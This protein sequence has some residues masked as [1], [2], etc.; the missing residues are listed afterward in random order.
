MNRLATSIAAMLLIA[1][2]IAASCVAGMREDIRFHLSMRAGG[3]EVELAFDR[4]GHGHDRLSNTMPIAALRGLSRSA[5]RSPERTPIAF[6]ID[7]VPGRVDCRGMAAGGSAD[8]GC[9]FARNPGFDARLAR[10]GF[11]RLDDDQQFVLTM[12]DFDPG[13]IEALKAGDYR[14]P[15]AGG[16]VSLGIFAI[17]A[18]YV[19]D[20]AAAG[21][22]VGSVHDLV[23]F[24]IAHITPALIA[25]YRQLGYRDLSANDLVKMGI[26]GITP[27]FIL[28][29]ARAGLRDI[30]A[31]KLIELKIFNVTPDDV[32]AMRRD[33]AAAV[34]PDMLTRRRILGAA[35]NG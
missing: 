12:T 17:H 26:Q 18:D 27:D 14:T 28:G 9:G 30:P 33:G 4:I 31:D 10:V 32:R 5:L 35:V 1:F 8:G 25:A 3:D 22:R 11:P 20:I 6:T 15:D 19:R 16:L 24:K 7:R 13:V 21:F 29:F 34:T 23:Q 2:A